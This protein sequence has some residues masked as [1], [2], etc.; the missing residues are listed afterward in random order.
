M[1]RAEPGLR[2]RRLRP[3]AHAA[4]AA[5]CA[6]WLA[7]AT[8]GCGSPTPP[9][10]SEDHGGAR[11]PARPSAQP[12]P[13][14]SPGDARFDDAAAY[15]AAH[16]GHALLVVERGE[17][18]YEAGHGGRAPDAPHALEEGTQGFWGVLAVA[19]DDDG[20]LDLDEPVAFTI[21]EFDRTPWK[22][23][24]RVR[25][26]LHFTS[27]LETGLR[28]LPGGPGRALALEMVSRPGERFQYGP[29]HLMVFAE[30][31]RRKL[32]GSDAA[33]LAYLRSRLLDPLGIEV[34]EWRAG[35]DG[36][37]DL[38]RGAVLRPRQWARF[39]G[40]IANGGRWGGRAI[41]ARDALEACLEGSEA[42]PGFGLTLWLNRAG[43]DS[44]GGAFHPG[45]LPD[46]VAATGSANQRLYVIP[47]RG[48]VIV[49]FGGKDRRWRDADF[50][51]RVTRV[52]FPASAGE[53]S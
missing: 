39:G 43:R 5:L 21:P 11:A 1:A 10:A 18:V 4:G 34:S 22:R 41:V 2:R 33:P 19:A 7:L 6:A 23:E 32:D 9:A 48:L 17:V 46:L 47:S 35:D 12:A 29:S 20:L 31:L 3:R 27:G 30:L 50:L 53:K 37:P 24:M 45:G 36:R 26:L 38:A 52:T 14:A 15:S 40:L 44:A 49:R 51:E 8:A 28:P 13:D 16:G 25:Q 42:N